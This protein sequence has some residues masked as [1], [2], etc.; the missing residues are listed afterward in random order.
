MADKNNRIYADVVPREFVVTP[1]SARILVDTGLLQAMSR[2]YYCARSEM[3]RGCGN[4]DDVRDAYVSISGLVRN[5]HR[6]FGCMD[7]G[8][9]GNEDLAEIMRNIQLDGSEENKFE[10]FENME[11]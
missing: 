2:V 7:P 10:D 1:A 5:W 8:V 9:V 3:D 11:E 6:V 4:R